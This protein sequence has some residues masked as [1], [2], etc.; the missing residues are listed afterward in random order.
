[1]DGFL[2]VVWGAWTAPSD[3]LNP[4]KR[5]D[6][7]LRATKKCLSSWSSKFIGSIKMQ[8]ILATEVILRLDVAMD[9]HLLSPEERALRHLLKK[10]LLG[11]ASLERTLARQRSRLLWLREGDA[12]THFFHTQASHQRRKNF[13]GHLLVDNRRV[14]DHVDKAEAV[15]SFFGE[16]LGSSV[17]RPFSL[18][19]DFLGI[20]SLDLW[21]IDGEFSV[22][23]VWKAVKDMPLDKCPGPDGFSARF[24]VVCWDI[25]KVDVMA[26]FNSLSRLDSCGFGVVNNALITL[27]PK[28]PRAEEVRDFRPISLIHGFAKWVAKVIANRLAPL[29]PQL[30]GAHQSAFVRGRCLHDI[31]M[32]VQGTARKLH[33]SK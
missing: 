31:F 22:E 29:L 2:D 10:K 1:V 25:I 21:Q 5:L 17:D 16:L 4:F 26:A 20:P 28:K 3:E 11:L 14:T 6:L 27:L 12:C 23:E 15:D 8:I 18:D 33:S 13:I 24:F 32:M 9:S 7:K 30:V 19:L